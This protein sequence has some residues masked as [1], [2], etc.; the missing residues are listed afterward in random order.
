M[1]DENILNQGNKR[2]SAQIVLRV[3]KECKVINEFHAY[4]KTST[5]NKHAQCYTV[6][7]NTS[8]LWYDRRKYSNIL[9]C[10]DFDA[11]LRKNGNLLQPY[12]LVLIYTAMFEEELY[13][14]EKCVNYHYDV[15]LFIFEESKYLTEESLKIVQRW[16]KIKKIKDN[17]LKKDK[18]RN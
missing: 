18:M 10:C 12:Y 7:H 5:Y 8:I 16:K 2:K 6:N 17:L 13:H 4:L 9:G 1:F 14:E 3:L 15:A 11:F